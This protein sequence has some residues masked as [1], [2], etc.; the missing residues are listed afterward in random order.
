MV[1]L[2]KKQDSIGA[3]ASCARAWLPCATAAGLWPV[4][5]ECEPH[6]AQ[7]RCCAWTLARGARGRGG[8]R[9]GGL[10]VME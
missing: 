3:C 4:L 6:A 8:V 5:A 10:V 2:A 7:A 1:C 9:G